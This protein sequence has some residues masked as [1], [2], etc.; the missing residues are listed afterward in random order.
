[1]IKEK[2]KPMKLVPASREEA[3]SPT[4]LTVTALLKGAIADEF[5]QLRTDYG[6]NRSQLL[7]QM[8]YHCLGKTAELKDFYRRL[9]ILRN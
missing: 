4:K 8:V 2:F 7:V 3:S 1:M 5:E 6:L 9:N